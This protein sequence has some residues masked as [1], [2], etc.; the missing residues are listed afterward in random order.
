[1]NSLPN[2][3]EAILLANVAVGLLTNDAM[4]ETL[5][6]DAALWHEEV[7]LLVRYQALR[8]AGH[9]MPGNGMRSMARCAVP[10]SVSP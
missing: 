8:S 4:V 10:K 2:G 3:S 6:C 5:V 1:M 7:I 9:E